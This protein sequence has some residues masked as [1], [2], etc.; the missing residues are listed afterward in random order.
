MLICFNGIDGSGKSLQAH[1][2][3]EELTA[4]GYPAV[5]V[6]SGGNAPLT[7]PLARL[8]KSILRRRRSTGAAQAEAPQPTSQETS[9]YRSYLSFTQ[10]IFKRPWVRWLWLQV[11]ML[12]HMGE[13]WTKIVPHLLAGK[14][15]VCDRYIYD[16]LVN[17]AVL[18]NTAP[19]QLRRQLWLARLY[20]VPRP[21]KWF[22]IDVPADVAW[23]RKDDVPDV[24]YLQRRIPL[25]RTIA[26]AFKLERLDGTADPGEIAAQVWQSVQAVLPQP[27]ATAL[28]SGSGELR[29]R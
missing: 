29:R 13:I 27:P 9:E 3:I 10:G 16:R 2:L 1:K 28:E 17:I 8:S 19:E 4:A 18:C 6:W 11:S 25:Y 21:N 12:E 26:D 5:Y 24:L 15:V 20:W 23:S 14:I 7:K 22:F